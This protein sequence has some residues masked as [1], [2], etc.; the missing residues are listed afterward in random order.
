MGNSTE[1]QVSAPQ[2]TNPDPKSAVRMPNMAATSTLLIRSIRKC[3]RMR[4]K[5]ITISV[6]QMYTQMIS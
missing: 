3:F 1:P 2:W 5:S 6:M 4:N